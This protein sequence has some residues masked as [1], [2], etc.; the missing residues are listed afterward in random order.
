[1]VITIFSLLFVFNVQGY[2]LYP[3]VK[4]SLCYSSNPNFD[5]FRYNEQI[6]HCARAVSFERKDK[7]CKRD[8]V[9]PRTSEYTVDHIIPLSL[10]GS[11]RNDNLWCQHKSINVTSQEYNAY[12]DLTDGRKTQTEAIFFILR[13]KFLPL[14][15]KE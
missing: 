11:N 6:A 9:W 13:L 10:G 12:T 3:P 15:S 2:L 8:G 14:T 4:G 1:M 7:I 5:G